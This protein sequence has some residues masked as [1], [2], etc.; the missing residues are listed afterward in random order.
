MNDKEV[1]VGLL[2]LYAQ[3]W[4]HCDAKVVGNRKGLTALRDAINRV[5]ESC[6]PVR[7]DDV[8]CNDGEGYVVV[9]AQCEDEDMAMSLP[10]PYTDEVCG[11]AQEGGWDV[12]RRI[13]KEA[14]GRPERGTT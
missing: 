9:V 12:L 2:H 11:A 1:K 3:F 4:W 8:F 14:H 10:T 5:L 13:T 7:S 6:Q